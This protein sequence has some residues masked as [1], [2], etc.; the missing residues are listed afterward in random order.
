MCRVYDVKKLYDMSTDEKHELNSQTVVIVPYV[1]D[2]IGFTLARKKDVWTG[3]F[4]EK[5][6]VK[7]NPQTLKINL[8]LGCRCGDGVIDDPL[9]ANGLA[10]ILILFTTWIFFLSLGILV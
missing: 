4:S 6:F 10:N 2:P 5:N 9:S 3:M 7:E 8:H 1:C